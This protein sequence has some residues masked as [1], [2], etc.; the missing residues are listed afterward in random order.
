MIIRLK[1]RNT[2]QHFAYFSVWGSGDWADLPFLTW[3]KDRA[4]W[5]EDKCEADVLVSF[6]KKMLTWAVV[7]VVGQ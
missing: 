3:Q 4:G 1:Y 5:I 2:D 7:E 6:Y